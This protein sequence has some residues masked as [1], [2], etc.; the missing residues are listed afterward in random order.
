MQCGDRQKQENARCMYRTV[1]VVHSSCSLA[2]G[3]AGRAST[4]VCS[5]FL[6][7]ALLLQFHFAAADDE[8][9]DLKEH[10]EHFYGSNQDNKDGDCPESDGG[11]G[12]SEVSDTALEREKEVPV[13]LTRLDG[14]QV[15]HTLSVQACRPLAKASIEYPV[16]EFT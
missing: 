12:I 16:I 10:A 6:I 15:I 1:N 9:V 5:V 4:V 14:V 2:M 13:K 8:K 7:T 3:S 11:N